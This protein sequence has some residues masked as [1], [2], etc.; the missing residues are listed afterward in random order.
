[1]R[2]T[3]IT[4]C[5]GER[6]IAHLRECHGAWSS[7]L[8]R[9]VVVTEPGSGLVGEFPDVLETNAFTRYGAYFNKGA[10]LA[11]ALGWLRKTGEQLDWIL[12]LDCDVRPAQRQSWPEERRLDRKLLHGAIRRLA[13]GHGRVNR[14][15]PLGYFQLWHSSVPNVKIN[16]GFTHAAAYDMEFMAQWPRKLHRMLPLIV[17]HVGEARTHW[18]GPRVP[19]GRIDDLIKRKWSTKTDLALLP[20][21]ATKITAEAA[22][23]ILVC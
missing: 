16:C 18:F 20:E 7:W 14:H 23:G 21:Y 1:M 11:T 22:E 5:V 9:H 6:Y 8:S 10:G 19:V 17:E 13:R 15:L 12:L 4:T 2:I 3:A